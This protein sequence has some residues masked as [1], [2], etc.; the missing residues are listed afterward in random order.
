MWTGR[1]D[2]GLLHALDQIEQ[3][4]ENHEGVTSGVVISLVEDYGDALQ[5]RCDAM[6]SQNS[7]GIPSGSSDGATW[8]R[9]SSDTFPTGRNRLIRH[10]CEPRGIFHW[11]PAPF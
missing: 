1:N 7:L 3:A 2:G 9:C 4:Y 5:E 10:D 8:Y 6:S 11:A